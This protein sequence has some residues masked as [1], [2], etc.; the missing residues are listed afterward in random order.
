[1][2]GARAVKEKNKKEEKR[3]KKENIS[4]DIIKNVKK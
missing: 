3:E 4:S 2:I 1:M